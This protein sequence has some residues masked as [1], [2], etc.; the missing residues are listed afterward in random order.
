MYGKNL[1]GKRKW[2]DEEEVRSRRTLDGVEIEWWC[3]ATCS[4][5]FSD[6]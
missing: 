6:I 5:F 1:T 3:L 4:G 2:R